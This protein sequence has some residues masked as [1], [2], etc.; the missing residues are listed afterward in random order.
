M[1]QNA[2]QNDGGEPLVDR[3]IREAYSITSRPERLISLFE[4]AEPQIDG[5][6]SDVSKAQWHF[7]EAGRLIDE[8]VPIVGNSFSGFE[9]SPGMSGE[10]QLILDKDCRVLDFDGDL[11]KSGDLRKG[12]TAPDWIWDPIERDNDQKRVANCL[13]SR[14]PGFLRLFTRPE[15]KTGRW[16]AIQASEKGKSVALS[17]IQFQWRE[18]TGEKFREALVLTDAEL[19]L[20]RHLVSGGTV[21]SFAEQRGRSVG[22]A[23]NQLKILCRKLAINSQQELLMLYT[24]FAHSLQVMDDDAKDRSHFC[25]RVFREED[26]Q[27]IAWEEHG[28][29]AGFPVI[30]FHP[31]FEGA[32]FSDEQNAAAREAGLRVL[33]PWRPYMGETT[34]NY[35]RQ[36]MVRDFARRLGPFLEAQGISRCNVLGATAG[37]PFAMGFLQEHGARVS[38][39]VLA[40]PSIPF[41]KWSDLKEVAPGFRRPL[42]LTRLAPAFARIY[43]RATVAG[44][45]KG[46]FDTFIDDFYSESPKDR[47]YYANSDI[48]DLIRRCAT[49]TFISQVD[50]PSEGVVLEASDF[51]DLCREID[52]PVTVAVGKT[53]TFIST[54]AYQKFCDRFGFELDNEFHRSGQLVMHDDP[55]R[56]FSMLRPATS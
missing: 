56:I 52:V 35:S 27:R 21:R 34:G 41:P 37:G 46:K 11:F 4:V 25:A 6:S 8:V 44:T 20:T 14:E 33:A 15:D 48:R 38:K 29:P 51:S 9:P 50:G 23:R 22:T 30:Y 31:F 55:R 45:L 24:G 28:D 5:P 19:A 3:L 47:V 42:Q 13:S 17:S 39:A 16:F 54:A 36:E 2:P 53:S 1:S 43:V 32:L 10:A 49:Y 12:Q 40:A 26:G 18:R 7:E